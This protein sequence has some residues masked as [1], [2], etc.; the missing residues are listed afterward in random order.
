VRRGIVHGGVVPE[1][2]AVEVFTL[3]RHLGHPDVLEEGG[4]L[5]EG[6]E[7]RARV[8]EAAGGHAAALEGGDD[9]LDRCLVLSD[10]PVHRARR[11]V[12]ADD[13]LVEH[14]LRRRRV[15]GV[16]RLARGRV[17]APAKAKLFGELVWALDEDNGVR[18]QH[19][20]THEGLGLEMTAWEAIEEPTIPRQVRISASEALLQ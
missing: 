6:G 12:G 7:L 13:E 1:E 16:V 18:A 9:R 5:V 10:A 15:D 20:V 17:G 19:S 2:A 3:G 4:D 8:V 14:L 11:V